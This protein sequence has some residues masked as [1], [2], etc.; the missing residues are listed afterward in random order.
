MGIAFDGSYLGIM[1]QK[2]V[3]EESNIGKMIKD[4]ENNTVKNHY[5]I[6]SPILDYIR[7]IK[8][9]LSIDLKKSE[10]YYRARIIKNYKDEKNLKE[11]KEYHDFLEDLSDK[12][13]KKANKDSRSDS[14]WASILKWIEE[15]DL[16]DLG[17]EKNE[18]EYY[19]KYEKFVEKYKCD[20][21]GYEGKEADAP[22]SEYASAGRINA[23]GISYLYL[24]E[25]YETA[26][27]E[28]KPQV[29]DLISVG[30]FIIDKELKIFD[31]TYPT[32]SDTCEDVDDE[33]IFDRIALSTI[34]SRPISE[35]QGKYWIT[36]YISEF[37]STIG[38]DGIKFTS[39]IN[40]KDNLVLFN[41]GRENKDYRITDSSVYRIG[42]NKEISKILPVEIYSREE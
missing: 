25:D 39:S 10:N 32:T 37:V 40:G 8:G 29:G 15:N 12:V 41:S 21:S 19:D 13:I 20:Y 42:T 30:T 11:L 16:S 31:V 22:P 34:F 28:V 38:F 35:T 33:I 18:R 14:N 23:K 3:G 2:K 9:N 26:I 24:A 27:W 1:L 6:D 7:K 4:L 17:G 5:F 36:Q